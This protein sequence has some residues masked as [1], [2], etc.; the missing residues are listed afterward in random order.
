MANVKK[1]ID[2]AKIE[3]LYRAGLLSVHEIGRECG[4]A[5][6]NIRHK[7]KK[8]GWKRD[9]TDAMRNATR[10][11]MVEQLANVSDEQADR[12]KK[13]SDEEL[14][15]LAA[16]TQVEVVRQHQ[17]TLGAGHSLV[18][19]MLS[20]LE[21]ATTQKGELEQLIK[22]TISPHR[23]AAALA[24]VSL[25]ARATTLRNLASS[26]REWIT[27]ERQAFN[28][29]EDRGDNK[30]QRKLD[31]MTAEQLR[32][33]IID[34]AKKMGIDLSPEELGSKAVGVVAKS[35]NGSGLKH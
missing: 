6:G 17:T 15:E 21:A 33:E 19:R 28:I 7:A 32:Q 12:I 16:K 27:M 24:S 5:E 29:A 8:E 1:W 20:E 23:Q 26:A 2:W 35:A 14:I 9:L 34:D 31:D 30:D 18:M 3:R 4:T 13:S 11:K 10:T 25:S 22:S